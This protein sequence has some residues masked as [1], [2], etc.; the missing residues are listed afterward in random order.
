MSRWLARRPTHPGVGTHCRA[1]ASVV[2]E[3]AGTIHRLYQKQD[4][5]DV[6]QDHINKGQLVYDFLIYSS[7]ILKIQLLHCQ[8]L[9]HSGP[10]KI[11]LY[12]KV[13]SLHFH[14]RSLSISELHKALVNSFE[15]P[16]S[17]SSVRRRT[18]LLSTD[19]IDRCPHFYKRIGRGFHALHARDRIENHI[20]H[21]LGAV[22]YIGSQ[23]Q[24]A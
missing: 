16:T 7:P 24:R 4:T 17:I 6:S 22:V 18:A 12:R 2:V 21:F 23:L 11:T 1:R 14:F 13:I 10:N 8:Q 3:Q 20:L 5:K 15:R 19:E 9:E